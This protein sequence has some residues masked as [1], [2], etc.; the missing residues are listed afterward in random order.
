VKIDYKTNAITS[1]V[2]HD[3][4]DATVSEG[5]EAHGIVGIFRIPCTI[6]PTT[7]NGQVS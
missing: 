6:M 3:S 4:K 1:S 7:N 5:Y 2:S